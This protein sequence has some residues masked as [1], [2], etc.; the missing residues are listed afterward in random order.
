MKEPAEDRERL[1]MLA[2]SPAVWAAHFLTA[3]AV[4]SVWCAKLAGGE[5][6]LFP[7]RIALGA[8]T[9]VA[10]GVIATLGLRARGRHR[11]EEGRQPHDRDTDLD[12]HRFLGFAVML[13]SGLSAV[14]V[15]YSATVFVFIGSCR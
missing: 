6:S 15:V 7:V 11:L 10:L 3:Y 5:G 8:L 12:R 1:W 13:I 2:A 14:A 4:V 9:V